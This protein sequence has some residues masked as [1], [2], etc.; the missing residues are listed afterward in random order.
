MTVL[1]AHFAICT[2]FWILFSRIATIDVLM[3]YARL[4]CKRSERVDEMFA[5]R[6]E[7]EKVVDLMGQL[8]ENVNHTSSKM[9]ELEH[10]FKRRLFHLETH[11]FELEREIQSLKRLMESQEQ[12]SKARAIQI[13]TFDT[14]LQATS[15]LIKDSSSNNQAI[16]NSFW[17]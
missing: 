13:D 1:I 6:E 2:L 3:S 12:L 15:Q 17:F 4:L 11:T 10:D 14:K 9:F 7:L 5:T 16:W 8:I